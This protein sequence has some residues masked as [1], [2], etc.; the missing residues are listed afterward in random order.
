MKAKTDYFLLILSLFVIFLTVYVLAFSKNDEYEE[1]IEL[2]INSNL[3]SHTIY[4]FEKTYTTTSPADP[5]YTD[6]VYRHFDKVEAA[7]DRL[8]VDDKD[9]PDDD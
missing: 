4:K 8:V 5:D 2:N 9:Q 6:S 3:E 7:R 1:R